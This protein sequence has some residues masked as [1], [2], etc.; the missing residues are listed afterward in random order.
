MCVSS[1]VVLTGLWYLFPMNLRK[2]TLWNEIVRVSANAL[3][4]GALVPVATE[5]AWVDDSGIR[6][7]VRMLSSLRLK[8]RAARQQAR[9]ASLATGEVNPFLPY[10]P[11]LFVAEVSDT[12]V[13][14]LNK[15]NVVRHHLLIVTREFEDQDTLLSLADFSALLK[16]VGEYN[17]LGFYNGGKN[18]GA[19]Q[20]HKH[21]QLVPLPLAPEGPLIPIEPLVGQAVFQGIFGTV[22]AFPF[23]HVLVKLDVR[24]MKYPAESAERAYT[25]YG[26]MLRRLGMNA[27]DSN[28]L[29]MQSGP[30]CLLVAPQWMLLIPRSEEFFDS[31][32]I[33]SLGFAGAL[34]VR[35]KKQMERVKRFGPMNLLKAVSRS[36]P[37]I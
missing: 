1:V 7:F 22:P 31:I 13:A 28:M 16:C 2:G 26:A 14:I 10:E 21:L 17:S 24:D 8:D 19:S 36:L 27:P 23:L 30:Y 29:Q 15:F 4:R 12:H 5:S 9:E 37:G 3:S 25:C 6:F 20:R 35:N 34:L 32:S 11:D 33:N 18:A